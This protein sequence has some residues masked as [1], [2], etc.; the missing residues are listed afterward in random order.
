MHKY[1]MSS[2]D[3][4]QN[5]FNEKQS[6]QCILPFLGIKTVERSMNFTKQSFHFYYNFGKYYFVKK[7][8]QIFCKGNFIVQLLSF[9]YEQDRI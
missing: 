7:P 3:F 5:R 9:S 8:L 4:Y 2:L 1:I 6:G